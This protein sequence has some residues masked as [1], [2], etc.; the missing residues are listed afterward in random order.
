MSTGLV[1]NDPTNWRI[2]FYIVTGLYVAV[3]II[4]VWLYN[5]PP[6][7]LQRTLTQRQKLARLDWIGYALFVP[8]LVLF[9]FALT[10]STGIYP[11]RSAKVI[12]PITIGA[13][14]LIA[15]ILYEWKFTKE[16]MLHHAVF[17]HGRNFPIVF[18][19]FF[20]EGLLFFAT[21]SYY[22]FEVADIFGK[23][24]FIAGA[25]YSVG[26]AILIVVTQLT[27]LY[28]TKTK[29][30]RGPLVLA[31]A[32]FATYCATMAAL[33][34]SQPENPLGY[35][36]LFGL[37]IG[38]SLNALTATAQLSTPKELI[39]ISTGLVIG[40]RSVGGTVGLAIF[41][42]IFSAT[43]NNQVPSKVGQ[44]VASFPAFNPKDIPELLEALTE[45]RTDLLNGIPGVTP[46]LLGAASSALQHAMLLAFRNIWIAAAA[47]AGVAAI[48]KMFLYSICELKNNNNPGSA[49]LIN[50]K[51]EFTSAID[52]PVE[53][54]EELQRGTIIEKLSARA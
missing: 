39:S 32:S 45:G 14:M 13:I 17:N 42:A 28:C 11:W 16:G 15:F 3:V 18:G 25:Y 31:F 27:G 29:T 33:E 4:I 21:N 8:G 46:K 23:P 26:W 41:S 49:F 37:G 5:P 12:A 20:V 43:R 38:I 44:A 36:V 1:R 48:G 24:L 6:R 54:Q 35:V 7:E 34:A 22:S 40:V 51:A 10:S 47:L 52:A 2:F 9:G 30:I 53:T 50:P 19:L